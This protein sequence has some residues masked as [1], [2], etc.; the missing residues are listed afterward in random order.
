MKKLILILFIAVTLFAAGGVRAHA[1]LVPS[2]VEVTNGL[3]PSKTVFAGY[4]T[5]TRTNLD[6]FGKVITVGASDPATVIQTQI[7]ASTGGTII[8]PPGT[9]SIGTTI[10]GKSGVQLQLHGATLKLT[11]D[12]DMFDMVAGFAVEGRAGATLSAA[13]I[14]GY[15][16]ALV[17]SDR[18]STD[19][20][21]PS[22]TAPASVFGL[23]LT[24][25]ATPSGYGI[26]L[27]GTCSGVLVRNM[28]VAGFATG[29]RL[30]GSTPGEWVNA[31][32][33]H[34]LVFNRNA[35]DID[36]IDG[37]AAAGNWFSGLTFQPTPAVT[38]RNVRCSGDYNYFVGMNWDPANLVD[39][40]DG[41]RTAV[42]VSGDYNVFGLP[43]LAAANIDDTGTGNVYENAL[44][45]D[46]RTV[47]GHALS[48]DV[49]VTAGDVGLG[50]VDNTAD[51]D[52]PVSTATHAEIVQATNGLLAVT[53]AADF[54]GSGLNDATS[55]GTYTGSTDSTF[56]VVIDGGSHTEE[57]VN[58]TFDEDA[59]WTKGS[60]WVISGGVA[61]VTTSNGVLTQGSVV[62]PGDTY[63]CTY[64]LSSLTPG[65]SMRFYMA[66]TTP[67]YGTTRTADGTYTEILAAT[68]TA[69][70]IVGFA[71]FSSPSYTVDN[72]SVVEVDTFKWRKAA[73]AYTE[74]VLIT[75]AAQTLQEG[76]K[77]TFGAV[78]GHT[79][80]DQWTV[81]VTAGIGH[82]KIP[83]IAASD[84]CQPGD[85]S[86]DG[87]YVY[88]CPVTNTWV[89]TGVSTW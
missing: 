18:V 22:I 41:S 86:V 85:W 65:K 20:L 77:L 27:T 71:G 57:V 64:T 56:T 35:V 60:G 45:P 72:V 12:V 24:G 49:T 50:N 87:D 54:T 38:T 73:G 66:G 14:A 44:V 78:T 6:G 23:K 82:F 51:M 74:G 2:T 61:S 17:V 55:S 10:T 43:A 1:E 15:S 46:T 30:D 33:M 31:N 37:S 76:V 53:G 70:G 81:D 88:F 8:L 48:A 59:A 63:K 62:T 28:V 68:A 7:N 89:R 21:R 83:P 47:N 36:V 67:T 80:N 19:P 4:T 34:G 11:A 84:P 13:D 9:Y 58:G 32:I 75:G 29:V 26:S 69:S 25:P 5:A 40:G 79:T 42:E 3:Y 16:H 52:K 39:N